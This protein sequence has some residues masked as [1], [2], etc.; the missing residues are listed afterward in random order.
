MN[1]PQMVVL[2]VVSAVSDFG[3]SEALKLAKEV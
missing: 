2:A 3:N 1:N